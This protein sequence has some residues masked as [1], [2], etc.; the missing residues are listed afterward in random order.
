MFDLSTVWLIL[1][2]IFILRYIFYSNPNFLVCEH[3]RSYLWKCLFQES[4]IYNISGCELLVFS[5][6][7]GLQ[8][9]TL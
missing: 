7:F 8:S 1:G 6:M 5:R 9:I 4:V 3:T 2:K